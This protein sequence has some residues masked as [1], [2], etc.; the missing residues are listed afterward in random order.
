[1]MI[2]GIGIPISHSN[3]LFMSVS[4]HR[5]S[6]QG[7]PKRPPGSNGGGS[8]TLTGVSQA[9]Q[10]GAD[11]DRPSRAKNQRFVISEAAT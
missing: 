3:A 10:G 4:R 2:R 1:M 5:M 8:S 7:T 6:M 11:A 9:P